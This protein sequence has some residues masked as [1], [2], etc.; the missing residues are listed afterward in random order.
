MAGVPLV[1]RATVEDTEAM[2]RV[3]VQS[4]RETYRGVMADGVLDDPELLP[5]RERFWR[6]ALSDPRWARNRT[7][8]AV[9]DGTVVGIAMAGPARGE[10]AAQDVELYVLYLLADHHGSGAGTAL[11]R[12]VTE[13][14]EVVL[15]WVA[16]PN[17]RAQAFY[18]K[19]GFEP[20]GA[21]KTEDD[22]REIQLVRPGSPRLS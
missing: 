17:P 3:H 16:D 19:H 11:L 10:K 9:V 8:V 1:R 20:D 4:W 21:T 6:A 13:P 2:A 7:S 5:G 15:L 18:R 12:D 14:E 22:V